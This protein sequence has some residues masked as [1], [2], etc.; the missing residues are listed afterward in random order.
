M[1]ANTDRIQSLTLLPHLLHVAILSLLSASIPLSGI[2]TS[3]LIA[4]PANGATLVAPSASELFRA[5]PIRALHVFAFSVGKNILLAESEGSF[6]QDEWADVCRIAEGLCCGSPD[7]EDEDDEDGVG[8]VKLDTMEM[9]A[10]TDGQAQSESL[11]KWLRAVIQTKVKH[12]QR[13]KGAS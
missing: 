3:T 7:I 5:K 10:A 8:G 2:L 12:E 13:W 9:D 11:E 4:I 1:Y 6:S